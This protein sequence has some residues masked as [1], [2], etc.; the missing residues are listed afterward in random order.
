MQPTGPVEYE[1]DANF[2]P[3]A[4]KAPQGSAQQNLRSHPLKTHGSDQAVFHE[5]ID[6]YFN[7]GA[8]NQHFGDIRGIMVAE[9]EHWRPGV[10]DFYTLAPRCTEQVAFWLLFGVVGYE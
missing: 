8:I 3:L 2:R 7:R 5:L 1:R 4:L 10:H 9:I 6:P